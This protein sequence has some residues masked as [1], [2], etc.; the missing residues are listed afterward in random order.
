MIQLADLQG[1]GILPHHRC[2][3]KIENYSTLVEEAQ[4]KATRAKVSTKTSSRLISDLYSAI[5]RCM[6]KVSYSKISV[7]NAPSQWCLQEL[8]GRRQSSPLLKRLSQSFT[9]FCLYP[10]HKNLVVSHQATRRPW[11]L[12]FILY[13]NIEG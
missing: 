12:Y 10:F 5:P 7:V 8:N 2:L 9:P 11:I 1:T 13:G 3:N 6:V 4:W